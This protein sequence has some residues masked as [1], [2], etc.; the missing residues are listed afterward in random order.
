M[1]EQLIRYLLG[2]LDDEERRDLRALLR[3]NPD[4]QRELAQL[5]ECFAS[6][7]DFDDEPAPPRNLAKRTA[8]QVADSDDD[9]LEAMSSRTRTMAAAGDPPPGVLG[10]SL[11]DLTVAGGVIL[12]VSMLLF[13]AL[14]ESRDGSRRTV[15]Q[16]N[17]Y[18]FWVMIT[19]Y[20]DN[21]NDY[22]PKVR[23]NENVGMF[24]VALIEAGEDPIELA[25][26]LVCPA[27][28][29]GGEIRAGR[30]GLK[31]LPARE[32]LLTMT[33]DEKMNVTFPTSTTYGYRL[34]QKVGDD[35]IYPRS[36]PHGELAFD[37]LFGDISG[38][39]LN[40]MTPNHPGSVIQLIGRNGNLK[41][42]TTSTLPIFG[43]DGDLYH[44][45]LGM[46]GVGL[47]A[48]DLVLAPSNAMLSLELP[49]FDK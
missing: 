42:F 40:P 37:P 1:R 9:V 21:H 25:R 47:G 15:C 38:D 48:H 27:S 26:L 4:L 33:L 2:E 13:P 31:I 35:Y 22:F 29:E 30:Q 32:Q 14:R 23:P 5:R 8:M 36:G 49:A 39:P 3:D 16:S 44:N 28:A 12:A 46:V 19:K 43:A 34:A 20:A 11:A 6:N 18:Q 7:Q 24:E 45:D 10:W 17:Q 41:S